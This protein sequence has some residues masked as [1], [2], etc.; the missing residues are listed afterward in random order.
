MKTNELYYGTFHKGI[1]T[2]FMGQEGNYNVGVVI[3]MLLTSMMNLVSPISNASKI[4]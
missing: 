2:N 1:N 3:Y 4:R